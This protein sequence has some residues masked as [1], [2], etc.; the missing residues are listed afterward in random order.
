M[1]YELTTQ[2]MPILIE[3]TKLR[4]LYYPEGLPQLQFD[5]LLI[6]L[7]SKCRVLDK[8]TDDM[9][10]SWQIAIK[11]AREQKAKGIPVREI[12]KNI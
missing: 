8:V 11:T 1:I 2:A 4:D 12:L 10:I 7:H 5:K 6:E 3:L 9:P